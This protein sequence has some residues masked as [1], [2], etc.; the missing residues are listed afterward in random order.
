MSTIIW[1]VFYLVSA[2][3]P[4]FFIFQ[5]EIMVLSSCHVN[6]AHKNPVCKYYSITSFALNDC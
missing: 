5:N 6:R 1:Y 3:S 2:P 4:W